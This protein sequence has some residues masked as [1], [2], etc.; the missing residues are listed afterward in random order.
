MNLKIG[1]KKPKE[2]TFAEK[3]LAR[4]EDT[5]TF[6]TPGTEEY[7]Y[8][9]KDR[10]ELLKQIRTE[11]ERF[12]GISKEKILEVAAGFGGLGVLL[13]FEDTKLISRNGLAWL[14]RRF[15]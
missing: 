6:V 10:E 13:G 12:G 15:R 7:G 3:E 2:P 9:L 5:M 4:L 11:K 8:L 14:N 1:K